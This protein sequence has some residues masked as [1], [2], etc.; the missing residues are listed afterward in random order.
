MDWT[1]LWR[2]IKMSKLDQSQYYQAVESA[3]NL[4]AGTLSKEY[5][6]RIVDEIRNFENNINA[7]GKNYAKQKAKT[8]GGFIAEDWH[9]GTFNM[10]AAVKDKKIRANVPKSNSL[11][12]EDV[13]T[14]SGKKFSLKYFSTGK[15]SAKSQSTTYLEHHSSKVKESSFQ[16]W[17]KLNGIDSDLKNVSVY[18]GQGRVIP[19]DQLEEAI[20]YVKKQ[21]EKERLRRPELVAKYEELLVNLTDR[22]QE[23]GVSSKAL[24][25]DRSTKIAT[26]SR[27]G[28]YSAENDGISEKQLLMNNQTAL[29]KKSLKTG[30]TAASMTLALE[31]APELIKIIQLTVDDTGYDF[32]DFVDKL[33]TSGKKSVDSFLLGTITAYIVSSNEAGILGDFLK[34]ASSETMAATVLIF[35]NAIKVSVNYAKGNISKSEMAYQISSQTIG[36]IG[37]A[38]G[39]AAL[40]FIPVIGTM[41][42]SMVG[43]I[44]ANTVFNQVNNMMLGIAIKNGCTFFGIVDQNYELPREILEEVGYD[45]F[46][47]FEINY[48]ALNYDLFEYDSFNYDEINYDEMEMVFVKR[49]VIGVNKIGYI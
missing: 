46:N 45:I 11:G 28:K 33:G 1:N 12:S 8:S 7:T 15:G 23:E 38:I 34:N 4:Q 40:Q 9:A 3:S 30:L 37:A 41:V 39:S 44:I 6:D 26:E 29:I 36:I 25:K 10:D 31:M 13:H 16:E 27:D 18:D 48:D 19:S 32:S 14:T 42:G 20:T 22:V 49:G 43:S 5:V 17:M 35:Y 24:S 21:I 2:K 47:Y